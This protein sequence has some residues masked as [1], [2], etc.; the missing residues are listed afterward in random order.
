MKKRYW[1][2]IW[3][4]VLVSSC[5]YDNEEKLYNGIPCNSGEISYKTDLLPI[6]QVNCYNCHSIENAPVSGD[7]LVLEGYNN[8]TVYLQSNT[9]TF[10]GSME[11]NGRAIAM[12]KNGT[13]LDKCS[14][15]AFRDWIDQGKLNN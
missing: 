12:P 11:Q 7:A 1:F 9:E 13:K 5:Y 14:I 10:M 2:F 3:S 4:V 6:F 15:Q 8:L